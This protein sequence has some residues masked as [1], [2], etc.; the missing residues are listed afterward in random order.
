MSY[1]REEVTWKKEE[2]GWERFCENH[3][4]KIILGEM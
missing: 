4:N 2:E 3:L 1:V